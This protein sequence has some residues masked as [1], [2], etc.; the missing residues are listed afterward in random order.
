MAPFYTVT[1]AIKD[2]SLR[3]GVNIDET[4]YAFLVEKM[5]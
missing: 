1:Y 2:I 5:R 3:F 4:F